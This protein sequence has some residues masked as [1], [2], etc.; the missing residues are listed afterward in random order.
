MP[1]AVINSNRKSLDD[2]R[3]EQE[4]YKEKVARHRKM[5]EDTAQKTNIISEKFSDE[6]TCLLF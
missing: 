1:S 5:G 6:S 3:R 2:M 4:A